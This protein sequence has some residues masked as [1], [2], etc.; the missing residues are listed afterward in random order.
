M[1]SARR[2]A[3][4]AQRACALLAIG[5]LTAV[6]LAANA[7]WQRVWAA[8]AR[9]P[10][11]DGEFPGTRPDEAWNGVFTRSEGW[12]G[13][14]VAGAVDLQDGRMLWLF[15]DSWIGSVVDGR[16]APGSRLVNNS[17]AVHRWPAKHGPGP[18]DSRSVQFY[19]GK[20]DSRGH[21]T[22][23]ITPTRG[24]NDAATEE[25]SRSAARL[26]Y[27]PTGGAA[28][29]P[30]AV[31]RKRLVVFLFRV[32]RRRP[33]AAGVW[34]FQNAGCT[35][36]TIDYWRLTPEEWRPRTLD[37]PHAVDAETA[38]SD[39]QRH[40]TYWGMAALRDRS[41]RGDGQDYLYIYGQRSVSPTNRQ[42]IL[43]RV[44][45][46]AVEQFGMWRFYASNGRW[47]DDPGQAAAL[48]DGL[49]SEFSVEQVA[50]DGRVAYVLVQSEPLFGDR[51]LVRT[52]PRPEGT[53]S[54]AR[55]VYRVPDVRRDRSYFTY[56]AKGHVDL[57]C[58]NKLV[59]TY[60]VN[61]NDFGSM[62]R[63]AAI[64]RPRFV[65]VPL[66]SIFRTAPGAGG[67]LSSPMR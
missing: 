28:V 42:L 21:P 31:G 10:E 2:T 53:W 26:W 40:E 49:V 50:G 27:W 23:W 34:N 4:E 66:R 47:S 43:A 25:N 46:A 19:W 35:L 65:R 59:V 12:T 30:D 44:P 41:D 20:S 1:R 39:P 14:D 63:D 16:H 5:L 13:G 64:Y 15:G 48:A 38:A 18:P 9:Q 52:A 22:A 61:S 62:V 45:T 7:N 36:A 32:A 67:E 51:I 58:Q 17:I 6:S 8:N 57:G 54:Q 55:A 33:K 24:G 29:V 56:A 3:D 11:I 60:V 37:L